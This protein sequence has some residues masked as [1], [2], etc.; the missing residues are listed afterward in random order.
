L[1]KRLGCAVALVLWFTMLC[2]QSEALVSPC[3]GC[4]SPV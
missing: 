4:R 3:S 2:C 1:T